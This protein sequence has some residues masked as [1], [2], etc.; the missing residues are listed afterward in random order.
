[1]RTSP[2]LN[3]PTSWCCHLHTW[4]LDDVC[5]FTNFPLFLLNVKVVIVAKHFNTRPIHLWETESVS[6]KLSFILS[7]RF[8]LPSLATVAAVIWV[9]VSSLCRFQ[10]A[11]GSKWSP[12]DQITFKH[13]TV[14]SDVHM[15]LPHTHNLM[16]RLNTVGQPGECDD[17]L[18][19]VQIL[20]K[21][22]RN[23]SQSSQFTCCMFCLYLAGWSKNRNQGRS[24]KQTLKIEAHL[25]YPR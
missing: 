24:M 15:H 9:G 1:M 25:K 3:T 12:M 2:S 22:Y 7:T 5:R 21:D 16:T 14:L 23:Q 18:C 19:L 11:A 17:S 10:E 13:D 4:Q 20:Y 8:S 6:T